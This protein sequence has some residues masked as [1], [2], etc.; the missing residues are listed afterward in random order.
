MLRKRMINSFLI[1]SLTGLIIFYFPN[2][3]YLL[4]AVFLIILA[5]KE[6]FGIIE[7]KGIFTYKYLGIIAGSLIP[8]VIYL[9]LG[10]GYPDVE[11]LFIIIACLFTFVLQFARRGEVKDH[12]ISI[13]VTL[14]AL[15]YISWF[16]S[17]FIKIK[18]LPGGEKLVVYLVLVTKIAD[19]A[20]YFVG[21][22]IGKHNL[23]PRIS[24]KKTVEG[25][26]GAL[27]ASILLALFIKGLIKISFNHALILGIMLGV[28]GQVGDLAESLIKRD[29]GVKD[30]GMSLSGFGGVLDMMDSLL[31]TTPIFYF[32]V[33]LFILK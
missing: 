10:E 27:I 6:F 32:Y 5:L 1:L 19:V 3:V 8:V 22:Y 12:V 17:F 14:L 13:A 4:L 9:N 15:F 16:L 33:K 7:S 20:A 24:P 29:C 30:S 11:P 18:F 28:T 31:F 26:V 25:T 21:S 23:I 2:W